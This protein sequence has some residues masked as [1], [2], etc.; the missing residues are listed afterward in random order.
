[1]SVVVS[2]VAE[3]LVIEGPQ[4]GTYEKAE[5]L[6]SH[7]IIIEKGRTMA[8]EP[9][10]VFRFRRNAGLIVEGALVCRG[11]PD[12]PIVFTSVN[13]RPEE[14]PQP[15]DWTGITLK[16][17]TGSL[18]FDHVHV[19]YSTFGVYVDYS[20]EVLNIKNSVFADNGDKN[21]SIVDNI[22]EVPEN[23]PYS[24]V[25]VDPRILA[26]DSAAIQ[27]EYRTRK[28]ARISMIG[29]VATGLATAIVG[30]AGAKK[31]FENYNA[32]DNTDKAA[33]YKQQD[34]A[35]RAAGVTGIALAVLAGVGLGLTFYF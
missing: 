3:E 5:Y 13:N 35:L 2:I 10:A 8:I 20:K 27:K 30:F 7:D 15:F 24:F 21:L 1:M 29:T 4:D 31:A 9:G 32:T 33:D 28:V 22:I 34:K 17:P 23:T 25:R 11:T 19:T 16:G 12:N 6:V 26:A 18:L 14:T